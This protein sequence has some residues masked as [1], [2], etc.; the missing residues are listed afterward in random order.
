MK[1]IVVVR[2]FIATLL[3]L[4]FNRRNI[5]T[6]GHQTQ[7]TLHQ[8]VFDYIKC[9]FGTQ[10]TTSNV[11]NTNYALLENK[12]FIFVSIQP[13]HTDT[14]ARIFSMFSNWY[15]MFWFLHRK[16]YSVYLPLFKQQLLCHKYYWLLRN[17]Q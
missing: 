1:S 8:R 10:T 7:F 11:I 17:L 13:E 14:H 2:L 5:I 15:S 3:Y 12:H 4:T 16:N 6:F 9:G